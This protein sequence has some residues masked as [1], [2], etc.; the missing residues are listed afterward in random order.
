MS[1]VPECKCFEGFFLQLDSKICVECSDKC[2]TCSIDSFICDSCWGN[3]RIVPYC[4]CKKGF[5]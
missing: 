1:S 4:N 3:N 2:Q 5:Y